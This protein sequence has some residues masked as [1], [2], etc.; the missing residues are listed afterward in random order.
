[1]NYH[2]FFKR[3]YKSTRATRL[4]EP[5]RHWAL[6]AVAL[7]AGLALLGVV[8]A[9]NQDGAPDPGPQPAELPA[10]RTATA[11]VHDTQK[12]P[13]DTRVQMALALPQ[14][15]TD[16]EPAPAH[17]I[18]TE[19]APEEKAGDWAEVEIKRGDTLSLIFS[20]LEI[21][22]QLNPI[23][24][25]GDAVSLLRSIHPGEKIRAMKRDGQL[26]QLVYEPDRT[27]Q[28]HVTRGSEG[29]EAEII[30]RPLEIRVSQGNGTIRSSLFQA[31]VDAGM[32]QTLI[33]SMANIFGWD[34]DFA[35]DIREGDHFSVIYEQLYQ[36]G[37]FV[38]DG[39]IL[40]AE[41]VNQGSTF[42]ALRYTTPE[43]DTDYYSPD[44]RSMRKAFLR[45]P[46]EFARVSSRFGA[47]RHPVLHTMRQHRGVDYAASTGTPI[48]ASGDGRIVHRGSRGGYGKTII[49]Q[50]GQQYRTLY[51]HMNG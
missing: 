11:A 20:R 15:P 7:A 12:R 3:D 45:T 29:Y 36:D 21:H 37:E 39:A 2:S 28:L 47:R 4:A 14:L 25:L 31:G 13:E 46:V 24:S 42:Q 51:A 35:M 44:G 34:V 30:D 1:M 50:H 33:M 26:Q 32:S 40:A 8:L 9:K 16:E 19:S 27:R 22:S 38:R 17:N 18:E 23:L 43:G 41:F 49:I 48:R 10:A 5:S 6:R